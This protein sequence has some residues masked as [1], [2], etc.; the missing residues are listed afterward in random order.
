[1][2]TVDHIYTDTAVHPGSQ[3]EPS[4]VT[5][6]PWTRQVIQQQLMQFT[7]LTACPCRPSTTTHT[8]QLAGMTQQSRLTLSER[9]ASC[10]P[11]PNWKE[12]LYSLQCPKLFLFLEAMPALFALT[13]EGLDNL[14]IV[15]SRIRLAWCLDCHLN[16]LMLTRV[17]PKKI[18][19]LLQ[20]CTQDYTP[21]A[22]NGGKY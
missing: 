6:K 15:P 8:L 13:P 5:Y 17:Q 9:R 3:P 16:M 20:I 14:T 7:L 19:A 10:W 18:V 12:L 2:T 1:M 21:V 11:T 4:G 22:F